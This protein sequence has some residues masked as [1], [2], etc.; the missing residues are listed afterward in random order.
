MNGVAIEL[1]VGNHIA[2]VNGVDTPIYSDPNVVPQIIDSRLF[3][4][5][6]F[7][8][9]HVGAYITWDGSLQ[10]ITLTYPKP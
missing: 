6:A 7:I 5:L 10:E 3:V 9:N 8:G 2:Q 1:Q 4:P